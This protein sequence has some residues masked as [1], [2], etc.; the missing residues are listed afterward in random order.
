MRSEVHGAKKSSGIDPTGLKVALHLPQQQSS[1]LSHGFPASLPRL[2]PHL[3]QL[4]RA[5]WSRSTPPYLCSLGGRLGTLLVPPALLCSQGIAS[6]RQALCLLAQHCMA[7]FS[8]K[9]QSL[10]LHHPAVKESEEFLCPS[11]PTGM[12]GHELEAVRQLAH[13]PSIYM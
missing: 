10:I 6:W 5:G 4:Q 8:S 13:I 12:A 9:H 2:I 3:G 11:L 1:S 7:Q